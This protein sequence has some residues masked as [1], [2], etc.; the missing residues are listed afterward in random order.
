MYEDMTPSDYRKMAEEHDEQRQ[1]ERA[2]VRYPSPFR[3]PGGKSW[4]VPYVRSWLAQEEPVELVE[5][6]AGGATVA[7]TAVMEGLVERATICELDHDVASVWRCLLTG[8]AE[9][10]AALIVAFEPTPD[11]VAAVLTHTPSD[12]LERAFRCLV[13]N[14][15]SRGG[16]MAPG[17]GLMSAGE[18]GR[19]IGSRWYAD[20]LARRLLAVA[21][22]AE[23]LTLI[24]GD[25]LSL[26]EQRGAEPG[27]AWFVDPPYTAP[28]KRAGGRLYR[29]HELD[30]E[31]LFEL[32]AAVKGPLLMTYD[33][34]DQV[35]AMAYRH[36]LAVRQVAMK[37]THHARLTE[38]LIGHTLAWA[39][40]EEA[41]DEA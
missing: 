8:G 38:L 9:D 24:E 25:A 16:I 34:A 23:R 30:H 37:N 1:A 21:E 35:R 26:L 18:D 12:Q 2:Q 6:F 29:H 14:R 40:Q 17:A 32:S 20:T 33:N 4:L 39:E 10:L 3:Y 22:H 15:T 11:S 28:G 27:V 13:H 19:G 36:D 5:P 41:S 7:L 31:R